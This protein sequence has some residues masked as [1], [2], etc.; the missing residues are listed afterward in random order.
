M[1]ANDSASDPVTIIQTYD[2]PIQIHVDLR[3]TSW[4]FYVFLIGVL[5]LLIVANYSC[6]FRLYFKRKFSIPVTKTEAI[7]PLVDNLPHGTEQLVRL[8]L[9]D[10]CGYEQFDYQR[11]RT[12]KNK[13]GR[14][15]QKLV[16]Y[17]LFGH[18]LFTLVMMI[19]VATLLSVTYC[20]YIF[21]VQNDEYLKR[22][23]I[24]FH[25][26][27]DEHDT[28]IVD[29][30]AMVYTVRGYGDGPNSHIQWTH[31]IKYSDYT[32]FYND[33]LI[34]YLRRLNDSASMQHLEINPALRISIKTQQVSEYSDSTDRKVNGY[35]YLSENGISDSDFTL[36][37]Q[38]K[39]DGCG[40]GFCLRKVIMEIMNVIVRGVKSKA[41]CIKQSMVVLV[42]VRVVVSGLD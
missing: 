27:V 19:L 22:Y 28:C 38:K 7:T 25:C 11:Y 3:N 8:I 10:F 20:G 39:C 24:P 29:S 32:N 34:P 5:I 4:Q 26:E 16:R 2:L 23:S 15:K 17:Q 31:H 30:D 37:S 40:D 35:L 36:S 42:I 41:T 21:L 18:T 12:S 1:T 14:L 13:I 6:C 9:V 33:T